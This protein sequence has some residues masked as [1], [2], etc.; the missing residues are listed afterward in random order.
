MFAGHAEQL[1]FCTAA[2]LDAPLNEYK[3]VAHVE[4]VPRLDAPTTPDAVPPGHR[5]QVLSPGP[6]E[7]VPAAQLVHTLAPVAP[8]NVPPGQMIHALAPDPLEVPTA[9]LVHTLAPAA[10]EYVPAMQFVQTCAEESA[11]WPTPHCTQ[12]E[13]TSTEPEAQLHCDVSWSKTIAEFEHGWNNH[14]ISDALKDREYI[15]MSSIRTGAQL[16]LS[17]T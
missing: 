15:R 1:R 12:F 17:P 14:W 9:Q 7:Y 13:F 16:P 11:N 4:Q 5:V 2:Q 3:P 10:P 6:L 8:E